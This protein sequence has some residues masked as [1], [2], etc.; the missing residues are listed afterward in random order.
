MYIAFDLL[1]AD[2]GVNDKP[3]QAA[4]VNHILH[5]E[6]DIWNQKIQHRLSDQNSKVCDQGGARAR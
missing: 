1:A 6:L 4:W 5:Q 3:S 2:L